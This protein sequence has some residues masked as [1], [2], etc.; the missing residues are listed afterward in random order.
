MFPVIPRYTLD[1]ELGRGGMGVVYRARR[2]DTGQVVALKLMLRGRGAAIEELA[3]FRIE[4]EALACL[5]HPNISRVIEVGVVEGCPYFVTEYAAQGTIDDCAARENKS[6]AW[7]VDA[8]RQAA[9]G[10]QHAHSRA[11]IH[12]DVKPANILIMEDGTPKVTDF[13]LVKFRAPVRELAAASRAAHVER[14]FLDFDRLLEQYAQEFAGQ[15][16]PVFAEGPALV[17]TL[18][19]ACLERTGLPEQAIDPATIDRFLET[20][21]YERGPDPPPEMACLEDLTQPGVILG[22]P[23]YMAPEQIAGD[24]AAI[25]PRTDVYGLGATLYRLLTGQPVA[26]GQTLPEIFRNIQ[27]VW[28]KPLQEWDARIPFGVE[29]VVWKAIQKD[30]PRR[31]E[32][33]QR[34]A[35]ELECC[36]DGKKPAAQQSRERRLAALPP[37]P[38]PDQ[39]YADAFLKA[40]PPQNG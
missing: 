24:Y 32:S 18:R 2:N 7:R 39:K 20:A 27:T 14:S 3:R 22:S 40:F 5:D 33:C 16:G 28:P 25:G 9:L 23:Q 29:C 11:M 1:G 6:I 19:R 13:G 35:E 31:Y 8:I 15:Y 36:L 38:K 17:D 10:L 12:R 34:F 26:T 4:A 30:P 37:P 21:L